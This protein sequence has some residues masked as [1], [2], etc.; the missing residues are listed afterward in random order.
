M[1]KTDVGR[2]GKCLL[3][4]DFNFPNFVHIEGISRLQ[5]TAAKVRSRTNNLQQIAGSLWGAEYRL[6]ENWM[7][8]T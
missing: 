1:V 2:S 3:Y 5:E 6:L 7:Y 8:G 4:F